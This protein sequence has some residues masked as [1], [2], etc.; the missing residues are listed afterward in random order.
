MEQPEKSVM[1]L[2]KCTS[3]N[4]FCSPQETKKKQK[5][6]SNMLSPSALKLWSQTHSGHVLLKS[7]VIPWPATLMYMSLPLGINFKSVQISCILK[8]CIFFFLQNLHLC[9]PP[10]VHKSQFGDHWPKT[11]K[12]T[13]ALPQFYNNQNKNN[14]HWEWTYEFRFQKSVYIKCISICLCIIQICSTDQLC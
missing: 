1:Q 11:S 14:N 8:S 9:R 6:H 3:S 13:T 2:L 7:L 5:K 4:F 12:Y 10:E